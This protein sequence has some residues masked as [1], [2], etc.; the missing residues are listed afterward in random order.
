MSASCGNVF[1]GGTALNPSQLKDEGL[2]L[3]WPW[4]ELFMYDLRLQSITETYNAIS[5]DGVSMT[6]SVNARF[7]L[8]RDG[9]A[10]LHKAI[11]YSGSDG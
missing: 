1:G 7:R 3:I 4:D 9:V 11:G 6:A 5:S 10:V 8:Q 2:H